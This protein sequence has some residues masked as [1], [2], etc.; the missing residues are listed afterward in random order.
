IRAGRARRYGGRRTQ[1]LSDRHS[2]GAD[3]PGADRRSPRI[4]LPHSGTPW[5]PP[6]RG[7]LPRPLGDRNRGDRRRSYLLLPALRT[8][9]APRFDPRL[10][11]LL[12]AAGEPRTGRH[13][14][15]PRK[16]RRLHARA[17]LSA[18]DAARDLGPG[19]NLLPAPRPA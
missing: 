2:R 9:T 10:A 15:A 6:A 1:R 16:L 5:K 4:G 14:A 11:T 17:A 3:K 8:D 18:S 13:R 7:D 19:G 12:P